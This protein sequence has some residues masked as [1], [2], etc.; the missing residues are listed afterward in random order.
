MGCDREIVQVLY[1]LAKN[2]KT[3][4]ALRE[5][6]ITTLTRI[7]GLWIPVSPAAYCAGGETVNSIE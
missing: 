4:M 5:N 6:R 1:R 7:T 2:A 3:K